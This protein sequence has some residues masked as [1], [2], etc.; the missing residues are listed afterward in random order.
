[1]GA[2]DLLR[3]ASGPEAPRRHLAVVRD[4][5]GER[6][7]LPAESVECV[8]ECLSLVRLVEVEPLDLPEGI[9][10][11]DDLAEGFVLGVDPR[12]HDRVVKLDARPDGEPKPGVEL[13]AGVVRV[14]ILAAN[15]GAQAPICTPSGVLLAEEQYTLALGHLKTMTY[16]GGEREAHSRLEGVGRLAELLL[17]G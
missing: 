16:V 11:G 8:Q 1:M 17:A 13:K 10:V 2:G 5:A 9:V 3:P 7:V 6:A 12:Q 15:E 14:E 4:D